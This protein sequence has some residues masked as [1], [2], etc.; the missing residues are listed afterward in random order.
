[1]LWLEMFLIL[2]RTGKATAFGTVCVASVEPAGVP[3]LCAAERLPA[4][5]APRVRSGQPQSA[6]D[7]DTFLGHISLPDSLYPHDN[8]VTAPR[9]VTE[10]SVGCQIGAHSK[11]V[12]CVEMSEI[13]LKQ[14]HG[15][16]I[17]TCHT[18]ILYKCPRLSVT[19]YRLHQNR[20]TKHSDLGIF[21]F[22]MTNVKQKEV[23]VLLLMESM[24]R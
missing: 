24:Q 20:F 17:G 19:A 4:S 8:G 2:W 21:H 10:T 5:A 23:T 7:T 3:L 14:V 12:S 15:A 6:P 9:A 13:V 1:M 18:V 16:A 11:C 22:F